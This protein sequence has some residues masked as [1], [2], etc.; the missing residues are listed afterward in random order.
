[1]MNVNKES[2]QSFVEFKSEKIKKVIQEK[3]NVIQSKQ[4]FHY[5][6][7]THA[8]N[9]PQS[10]SPPLSLPIVPPHPFLKHFQ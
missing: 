9:E 6:T 8:Y 10:N 2:S 5:Y 1:M 4:C 7:F 3:L